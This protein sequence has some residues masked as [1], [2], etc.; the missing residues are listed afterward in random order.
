MR[1]H[2]VGAAIGRPPEA[3][4][5]MRDHTVGAAIG[6]P[7]EAETSEAPIGVVLSKAQ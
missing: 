5:P 1:D 7:P 4:P 3:E 2:A 6:R